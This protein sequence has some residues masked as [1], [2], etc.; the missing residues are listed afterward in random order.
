MAM[1]NIWREVTEPLLFESEMK[2]VL[3]K[4]T[5]RQ[6]IQKQRTFNEND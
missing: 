2:W 6:N 1:F 5:M 4:P 3:F